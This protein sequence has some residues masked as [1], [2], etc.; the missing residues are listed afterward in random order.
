MADKNDPKVQ[1]LAGSSILQQNDQTIQSATGRPATDD[2]LRASWLLGGQGAAALLTHPDTPISQLLTPGA[3]AGNRTILSPNMTGAQALQSVSDYYNTKAGM[4]PSAMMAGGSPS[5]RL[6]NAQSTQAGDPASQGA[7]IGINSD[8][9]MSMAKKLGY[10]PVTSMMGPGDKYIAMGLGMLGGRTMADSMKN[11]GDAFQSVRGQDLGAVSQQNKNAMELAQV[12]INDTRLAQQLHMQQQEMGIKTQQL[13]I[14]NK[15][16]DATIAHNTVLEGLTYGKLLNSNERVNGGAA[17][18]A[19]SAKQAGNDAEEIIDGGM[20]ARIKA[21]QLD[22]MQQLLSSG[23]ASTG[24]GIAAAKRAV[25]NYFGV[26]VAGANP[27]VGQLMG[28]IMSQ[29]RGSGIM[30]KNMRTQR[31]FNTV[32]EGMAT[33]DKSPAALTQVVTGIQR[34]NAMKA[35]LGDAWGALPPAQQTQFRR[36]PDALSS[37][38]NQVLD[39]WSRDVSSTGL[40]DQNVPGK[41]GA[42]VTDPHT[43]LSF[44]L[45]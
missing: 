30:G 25:A 22:A 31:E 19:L 44:T 6:A 34:L 24:P 29:E 13:G 1:A 45:H 37:W 38:R 33:M 8:E 12:G 3:I 4:G 39:Q 27:D 36:D 17:A 10:Q 2:Q 32:M 15:R 21:P 7:S 9:I 18:A 40:Y 28:S 42:P 23:Q 43:G 41:V 14:D 11:A 5:G 16:A 20:E 35:K 26:Q